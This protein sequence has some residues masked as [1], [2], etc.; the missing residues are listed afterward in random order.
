MNTNVVLLTLL[1]GSALAQ[2]PAS[3]PD[4]PY[5]GQFQTASGI[6]PFNFEV[7]DG[8]TSAPTVYLLNAN[9]REEL[10]GVEQRGDSVFIPIPLYDASLRFQRKGAK[11]TGVYR[12][13]GPRSI[14]VTPA[15][16]PASITTNT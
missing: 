5:R 14:R 3:L 6:V 8:G 10:K 4:G 9:E 13:N 7:K 11:L 15:L 12:A 16:Q 2:S 1:T